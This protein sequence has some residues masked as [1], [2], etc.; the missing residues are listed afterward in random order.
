MADIGIPG[1]VRVGSSNSLALSP[2]RNN[3]AAPKAIRKLIC[4]LEIAAR[5]RAGLAA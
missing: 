5:R 1:P 2:S 4:F 3:G